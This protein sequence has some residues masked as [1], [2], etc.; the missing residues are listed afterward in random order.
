MCIPNS[1]L[2]PLQISLVD[3]GYLPGLVEKWTVA[4]EWGTKRSTHRC[5]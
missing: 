3:V 1:D 4:H 2:R 5:L